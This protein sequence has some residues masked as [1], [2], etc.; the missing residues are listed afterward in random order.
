[1]LLFGIS[2]YGNNS[3][4]HGKQWE[5]FYKFY[6]SYAFLEVVNCFDMVIFAVILLGFT[7]KFRDVLA[8]WLPCFKNEEQS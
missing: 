5:K 7:T 8:K 4:R 3:Y 2:W 1:M 6:L